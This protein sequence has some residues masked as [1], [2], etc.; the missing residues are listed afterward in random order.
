MRQCIKRPIPRCK[1]DMIASSIVDKLSQYISWLSERQW[2]EWEIITIAVIALF[3]LL[4]IIRWQR[5]R[6]IRNIYGNQFLE[7]TPVIGTKLG[8]RKR[9]RH[10]IEDYKKARLAAVQKGHANQHKMTKKVDQS[11]K[12]H[13]QI[14]QL[15]HD[16]IKR[17]QIEVR[18]DERVA[19]LTTANEKLQLELVEKE[20]AEK[21]AEEI[22]AADEQ[23]KSEIS[24]SKQVEQ[25][26]ERQ[27]VA[28]PAVKKPV[29]E[30]PAGKDNKYDDL[31]RIVD[32]VEQKLCRKCKEWKPESEFHKNASSKDGLVGSC[33]TC[34]AEAARE[35]RKRRAAGKE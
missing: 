22:P 17:K 14:K 31:H 5:R 12:L 9:R 28:E 20:R 11:E 29:E 18:L 3:M 26:P 2:A 7:N 23:Q 6:V 32:D 19:S 21:Q 15:Q 33:K 4:W 34:K 24:E 10:L 30:K 1:E 8:S 16:I 25:A 35:Y 13:E 27:I